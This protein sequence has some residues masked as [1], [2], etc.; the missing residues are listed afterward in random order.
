M[1]YIHF[2]G[3]MALSAT[4]ALAQESKTLPEF[5][6]I[7]IDVP[8]KIRLVTDN[9]SKATHAKSLGGLK[10]NVENKVLSVE[11][12]GSGLPDGE[13][14]EIH[15]TSLNR[16]EV[17]GAVEVEMA[18]DSKLVAETLNIECSGASKMNMNLSLKTLKL[19]CAGA[20]KVTLKGDA[21]TANYDVSGA[22]KLYASEF[23]CV[24]VNI[25]A[26]GATYFNIFASQDLNIDAAGMTKGVYAGN[27]INRIINVSGSSN[28]VDANTGD[29]MKDE[30]VNSDDTT[31]ITV[32]KKKFI[33][34]EEGEDVRIEKFE[35]GEDG[36]EPSQ[37]KKYDLKKV[38]AGFELGMNQF[39]SPNLNFTLPAGYDFLD[40]KIE[41]S[42]FFGLNLLEGDLQLVR[43]K[44]AITSGLGME[45]QNFN[46]NS[47]RVLTPNVNLLQADSGL[48]P[49]S[50]N[51]L[52]T[53]NLNVPLLIKYAPR[54]RKERNNFHLA[55][56]VIGSFKAYSH[57]RTETSYL[58]FKQEAKFKDDYDINPFRLTA[59]V[60][61]GYGWFRAF[62]N[63]SLTP[64]FNQSHANPDLRVFSAGITLIPFQD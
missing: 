22:S 62:A 48:V 10:F 11:Y 45:F 49:L 64:Y 17:N 29:H 34:I 14:V 36:E 46:F 60:R 3:L 54:T 40:C 43:N 13:P 25:D 38:Y 42:W 56:G 32:G 30:R 16:I 61:V 6:Q 63:Y 7:E 35:D 9:Q 1:K 41:K 8:V 19:D 12:T 51:K 21:N 57:V 18:A 52:Y 2:L 59:T 26:A 20:S 55:A 4:T 31:K 37:P 27:P 53:Y 47:D 15:C 23:K 28:I 33:I 39:T 50:K 44:L 24:S 58:G 5:N